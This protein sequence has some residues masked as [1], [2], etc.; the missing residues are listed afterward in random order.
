[1]KI[2]FTPMRLACLAAGLSLPVLAPLSAGADS[3]TVVGWGGALSEAEAQAFEAP[4]T[5][6]TGV[7]II[8][9]V[10][11]GGLAQVRA[12][13]ESGHVTWDVIDAEMTDATLGCD[14]GLLE[15][16]PTSSLAPG[17][18]GSTPQDDF[19]GDALQDCGVA[20]YVW[21]NVFAFD[22]RQFPDGGPTSVADLFDT[23]RFPGRRGLR[24]SPRA[25]LEWALMADGVALDQVY[26]VLSTPEG[27]DR[28]FAVLDRVKDDAIWWEAGAQPPQLLADG[29]VAMTSA[30]NGRLFNAI[31]RE[32]QPFEIV[33]DGQVWDYGAF[34]IP[35][36]APNR[37]RALEFVRFATAPEQLAELT[38]YIS[39]G[40]ARASGV[41]L[42]PA[43]MQA[44]LP[45]AE[46]NFALGLRSSAEFWS[47]Y[48]E[49]L[50]ARFNAWLA[51][52]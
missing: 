14:E 9:E 22:A 33:W 46:A 13:A 32:G 12:Q 38:N 26:A 36:G 11:N 37:E 20:N 45:T 39:Y 47:D 21:A 34:I 42:V 51:A 24:R 31:V 6:A 15:E 8:S 40:P 29:E 5:A 44:Q 4:F 16:I 25:N 10:Y 2:G 1:M 23:E 7:E 19:F 3:L 50:E 35:R 17:A 41:T 18:D 52:N 27:V 28:A 48:G 49:Q 30:Y 43:E